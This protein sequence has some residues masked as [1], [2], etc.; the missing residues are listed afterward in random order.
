MSRRYFTEEEKE[1]ALE[2][3]RKGMPSQMIADAIGCKSDT[4]RKWCI[5]AGVSLRVS[6]REYL[7]AM[8]E[9]GM[10]AA[11]IWYFCIEWDKARTKVRRLKG[12]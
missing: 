7:A 11:D 4:V 2:Y 3:A 8:E 12:W 5:N 10:S 1:R 6:A 9:L